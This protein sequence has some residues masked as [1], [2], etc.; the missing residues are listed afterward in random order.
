[1]VSDIFIIIF[2]KHQEINFCIFATTIQFITFFFF[3]FY[4]F[5]YKYNGF[6]LLFL[7]EYYKLLSTKDL[8]TFV[9]ILKLHQGNSILQTLKIKQF[10]LLLRLSYIIT[11]VNEQPT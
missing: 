2:I 6:I 10:S 5:C 3:L 9:Y 1:M 4:L 11:Y 7:L 8:H